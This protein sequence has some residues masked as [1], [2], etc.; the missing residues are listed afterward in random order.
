[1]IIIYKVNKYR[2]RETEKFITEIE[3][4]KKSDK[5]Y[6]DFKDNLYRLSS[7]YF[8]TKEEAIEY[9]KNKFEN[10]KISNKKQLEKLENDFKQFKQEVNLI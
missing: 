10:E 8:N 9:L 6:W 7:E 4:K 2:F 5:S 3:V 1:M